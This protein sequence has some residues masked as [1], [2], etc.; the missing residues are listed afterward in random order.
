[1]TD[2]FFDKVHEATESR[3]Q[4]CVSK[5]WKL[6]RNKQGE[7]V[8]LRHVLEKVAVWVKGIINI[9]DMGI[10]FDHSGH[11]ALPWAIVK[12]LMTVRAQVVRLS[13]PTNTREHRLASQISICSA[14][15]SKALNLLLGLWRDMSSSRNCI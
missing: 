5:G 15:L 14:V 9:V 8:K 4:D 12:Y 13:T 3:K 11:A 10:S 1:M 2:D 7:E 6:Y